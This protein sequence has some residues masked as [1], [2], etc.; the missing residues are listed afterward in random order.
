[1]AVEGEMV[2]ATSDYKILMAT[3][4]GPVNALLQGER[5]ALNTLSRCSGVATL[6]AEA[7][8][9]ARAI[10]WTGLVA[11]TR[12]TTP[13]FRIVEK[14]GLLVGGTL[15]A[16]HVLTIPCYAR[17]QIA[18]C[19]NDGKRIAPIF[20]IEYDISVSHFWRDVTLCF[21]NMFHFFG[22]GIKG[23]ATHRLDL[24][25][26]VMLKDNHIWSAGS[27]TNAVKL[28]R[29]AAGFSQKIEVECQN[30]QEALEAT[31]AG[32]DVSRLTIHDYTTIRVY[33][34]TLYISPIPNTMYVWKKRACIQ[35]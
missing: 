30:L 2:W 9:M 33:S 32:A 29:K 27:I 13:G 35:S 23:A 28:A 7:V 11:G 26:M 15:I 17:L 34:T 6:S 19:P 22:L 3:V 10:G 31:M 20:I 24:S 18:S 21:N 14:Y 5:T 4:S 8:D 25:Q 12:K 16:Y 1:V